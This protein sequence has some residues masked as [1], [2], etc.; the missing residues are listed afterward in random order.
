VPGTYYLVA[1]ATGHVAELYDDLPCSGCDPTSGTAVVVVEG[2]TTGDID[3]ELAATPP[4]PTLIYLEDCKPGGCVY[5]KSSFEDSRTNRS[6]ILGVSQAALPEFQF[7][8]E[9][10]ND[11]VACVRHAYRPFAVEI[12]DIDP[13]IEPHLEHV[14]AGLPSQIGIDELGVLG[15]SPFSCGFLPNS[16]SFTFAG[17]LGE[18]PSTDVLH[19]LCWTAIHEIGHQHG[20]DHHAYLQDAMTHTPGCEPKVLPL[21][22]VPCGEHT[23]RACLCGGSTENSY[24]WI[25]DIHGSSGV[26]FADGFEILEPGQSCVWNEQVPPP[27]P[28]EPPGLLASEKST[29]PPPLRCGTFDPDN[30]GLRLPAPAVR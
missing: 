21:R 28:P 2:A 24:E 18:T 10:W 5:I 30:P 3:F 29:S 16:I 20:L 25:R 8:A 17:V 27:E 9:F 1:S 6:A 23:P 14:I 12:T 22:D 4:E 19:E 7:P 13:G 15:V 26:L 11:L